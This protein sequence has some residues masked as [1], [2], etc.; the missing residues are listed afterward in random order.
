MDQPDPKKQ[1][2]DEKLALIKNVLDAKAGIGPAQPP[3]RNVAARPP[4][5]PPGEI[6]GQEIPQEPTPEEIVNAQ[7]EAA[8]AAR[9]NAAIQGTLLIE[10]FERFG[11][12]MTNSETQGI[13]YEIGLYM[14]TYVE[15]V[16]GRMKMEREIQ[17]AHLRSQAGGVIGGP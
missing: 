13:L 5:S 6:G 17:D 7:I 11:H 16:R 8:M 10:I 9:Q 4:Q 1:A 12:E 14:P 2:Q 15:A 3:R